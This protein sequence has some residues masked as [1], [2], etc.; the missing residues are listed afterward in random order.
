MYDDVVEQSCFHD[1]RDGD[2]HDRDD[3]D[4]ALRHD[5]CAHV[6]RSEVGRDV[7]V[8]VRDGSRAC[9]DDCKAKVHD[10]DVPSC[11]SHGKRDDDV[12]N[13]KGRDGDRRRVDV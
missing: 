4:D 9:R 2:D 13:G 11:R 12:R 3:H 6:H 7:Y 1:V 10:V 8:A 5:A